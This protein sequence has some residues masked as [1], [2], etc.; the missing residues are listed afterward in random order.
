MAY[1]SGAL[2]KVSQTIATFGAS[3]EGMTVWSYK[4]TDLIA[5]IEATDYVTDA[6]D[7]G[8][9]VGDF[10]LISE[11]TTPNSYVAVVSAIDADGN[12]T[13]VST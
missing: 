9:Q 12:A 10:V 6:D 5:V 11:T 2:N 1:N 13:L 8:M 7:K 4:T 3:D